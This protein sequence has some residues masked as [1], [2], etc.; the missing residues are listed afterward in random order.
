MVAELIFR[1][2]YCGRTYS[3]LRKLWSNLFSV[4]EIVAELIGAYQ[5]VAEL[6]F[7]SAYLIGWVVAKRNQNVPHFPNYT[8]YTV[9]IDGKVNICA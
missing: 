8:R 9:E 3:R 6:I 7:E 5:I 1:Y 4:T 2:E